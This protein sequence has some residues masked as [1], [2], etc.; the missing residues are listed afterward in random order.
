[1]EFKTIIPMTDGSLICVTPE[2]VT[3]AGYFKDDRTTLVLRRLTII[4]ETA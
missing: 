2:G 3:Y 1:M 4:V